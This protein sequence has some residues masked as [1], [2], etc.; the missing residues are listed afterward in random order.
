VFKSLLNT[1][2]S[3]LI[4]LIARVSK[5]GLRASLETQIPLGLEEIKGEISSFLT[6]SV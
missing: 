3:T 4:Q 1:S 5:L 6:H 2:Q